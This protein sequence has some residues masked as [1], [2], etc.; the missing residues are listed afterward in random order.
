MKRT[1]AT[2]RG[3]GT[4][5]HLRKGI[6]LVVLCVF[7]AWSLHVA[8]V[9]FDALSDLTLAGLLNEV[10]RSGDDG[11]DLPR[12]CLD[13]QGGPVGVLHEPGDCE[14]GDSKRP[15]DCLYEEVEQKGKSPHVA[16][17][18][19]DLDEAAKETVSFL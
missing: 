10:L 15:A 19:Q 16:G 12:M 11:A 7:S 14:G 18:H 4:T 9:S 17:I 8:L 5:K 3:S 2:P 1:V 13:D 6:F